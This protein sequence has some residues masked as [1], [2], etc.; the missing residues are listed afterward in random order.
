[1]KGSN[2][3]PD[4]T[5]RARVRLALLIAFGGGL[6]TGIVGLTGYNDGF[7]PVLLSLT[8]A[9]L[10]ILG[11]AFFLA[12]KTLPKPGSSTPLPG[13]IYGDRKQPEPH[14]VD[15]GSLNGRVPFSESKS[16]SKTPQNPEKAELY[17]RLESL[18]KQLQRANVK[19]GLG[20]LSREGYTKIVA[21]LKERR[22]KVEA[23]LNTVTMKEEGMRS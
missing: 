3:E 10:V 13:D 23:E 2:R 15:P 22:A 1:M 18:N 17:K 6:S 4:R 14:N 7:S 16:V 20:E 5:Q 19:L 9:S 21:E 12:H 11:V 8:V